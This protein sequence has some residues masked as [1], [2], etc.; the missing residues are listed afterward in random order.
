[1]KT[2]QSLQTAGP[3]TMPKPPAK[4]AEPAQTQ[5]WARLG[6]MVAAAGFWFFLAKGLVWLALFGAAV[7]FGVDVVQAMEPTIASER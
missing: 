5:R 1:M 3:G 2:A 7:F 6:R 4:N